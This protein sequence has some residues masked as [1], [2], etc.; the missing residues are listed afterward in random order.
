MADDEVIKTFRRRT[1]NEMTNF[2]IRAANAHVQR[3]DLDLMIR[4][5]LRSN[6]LH[7]THL[8]FAG[9]HTYSAHGLSVHSTILPNS[10]FAGS[11]AQVNRNW[12]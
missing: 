4:G 7:Q 8:P 5:E 6:V 3:A 2:L 1:V 12:D 11:V 10:L 9:K